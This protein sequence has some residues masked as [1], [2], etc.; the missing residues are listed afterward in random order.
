MAILLISLILSGCMAPFSGHHTVTLPPIVV[1]IYG[2]GEIPGCPECAGQAST[3]NEIRVVAWE[4]DGKIIIN[5]QVIGHE[6]I[7]LLHWK[8]QK[9]KN[10][11]E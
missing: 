8:D 3:G 6:M 11:D 10:P 7:H 2:P 4:L 9:I 5:E 1:E